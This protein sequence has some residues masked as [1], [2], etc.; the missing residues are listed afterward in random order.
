MRE[1]KKPV[2]M[3]IFEDEHHIK[4]QPA[5]LAAAQARALHWLNF[6]LKDKEDGLEPD[7]LARWRAMRR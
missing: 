4:V 7:Q 5:H 2:E 3:Y 6:W 1:Q